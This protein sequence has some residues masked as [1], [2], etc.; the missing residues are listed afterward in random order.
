MAELGNLIARILLPLGRMSTVK[1][2]A[3]SLFR[4]L[5]ARIGPTASGF[6]ALPDGFSSALHRSRP[7]FTGCTQAVRHSGLRKSGSA[8][9]KSKEEP[10]SGG[11][12]SS[13]PHEATVRTNI[14]GLRDRIRSSP[15]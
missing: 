8:G 7:S 10:S 3:G 15:R 4:T 2:R 12:E 13:A 11:A 5:T 14:P 6:A 1:I 9:A